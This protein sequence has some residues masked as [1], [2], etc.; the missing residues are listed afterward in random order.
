MLV[1]AL[2]WLRCP[3][4]T[5]GLTLVDRVVRCARGHSFDV[6]R[7]G[8]VNLAVGRPT[9]A[10]DDAAMVAARV[11]LLTSGVYDFV[12]AALATA[13]PPPRGLV[14][15]VG[16][17][18]G[19]HLAGVLSAWPE[20]VGLAVDVSKPALRR[21]ARAHPRAAAVLADVWRGL[22]VAD[23]AAAVVLDVFAPRHG[24]ELARILRPDGTVLVV[25]PTEEH[26]AELVTRLELLRVAPDKQAR[27]A[28]AL[29][30]HLVPVDEQVH[31][32][33]IALS[34]SQV[35]AVVA[36]GPSARHVDPA[37]LDELTSGLP[38]PLPVT[39]SVRLTRYR[40]ARS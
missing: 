7:Q 16:A 37:R 18:P 4:C 23:G 31:R 9:H 15:D 6:A 33:T 38:E 39:A 28:A 36:M 29:E 35:R 19:H 12:T 1:D 10:G 32:R 26:L 24:A 2:P 22:P 11:A 40:R 21:A 8:Y 13:V 20:A 17:G 25:T 14:V 27:L 3:H 30:P 5:G 34:R